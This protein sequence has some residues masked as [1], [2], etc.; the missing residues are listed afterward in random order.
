MLRVII[1]LG[2]PFTAIVVLLPVI[3]LVQFTIWNIPFLYL[4]LFA[5]FVLTSVCLA[6]CWFSFDQHRNENS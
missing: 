6:I 5:W 3:N 2:I 4:W 1:G